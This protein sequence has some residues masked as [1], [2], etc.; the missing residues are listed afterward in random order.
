MAEQHIDEIWRIITAH[1]DY[2]V[3]NMGRVRRETDIVWTTRYGTRAIIKA[4]G[5]VLRPGLGSHDYLGVALGHQGHYLVHRLVVQAFLPQ[6]PGKTYVNHINGIK[7]DNRLA[8]V[9]WTNKSLNQLHAM[10]IGLYAGP[11][12]QGWDGS[13]VG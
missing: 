3:S 9:E 13:G 10:E 1:P 11:L 6:P 12:P 2:A 7:T 5:R 8:N 4:A